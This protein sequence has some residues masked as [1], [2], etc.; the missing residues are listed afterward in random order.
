[1][2]SRV[3]ANFKPEHTGTRRPSRRGVAP[4]HRQ[5]SLPGHPCRYWLIEAGQF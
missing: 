5:D 2:D 4:L 1:L 3:G